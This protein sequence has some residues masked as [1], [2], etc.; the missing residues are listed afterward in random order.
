IFAERDRYDDSRLPEARPA[1]E[2]PATP[3]STLPETLRQGRVI[4]GYAMTFHTAASAPGGCVLHP[5]GLAVQS[6]EES[7]TA[8]FHATGAVCNLPELSQAAGASGF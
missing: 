5:V 6:R 7:D 8:F 2:S 1:T 4:L 3:D